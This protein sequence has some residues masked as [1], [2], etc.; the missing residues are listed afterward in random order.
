MKNVLRDRAG[1]SLPEFLAYSSVSRALRPYRRVPHF[2]IGLVL[3]NWERKTSYVQAAVMFIDRKSDY[4]YQEHVKIFDE[5]RS[6]DHIE[7]VMD[8]LQHKQTIIFFRSGD[9]IPKDLR[10]ALDIV[11][12]IEPPDIRQARGV[13]RWGYR[14]TVTDDQA[15]AL[16]NCDWRRLK[17]AMTWGRPMPRVLAIVEK[18]VQAG[19]PSVP[20]APSQAGEILSD[21]RLEDMEGYGDAK[22]W[23]LDL[24][25][26]LE[27]WRGGKIAWDDVDK[28]VLLSGPPGTGKTIF[29]KALAATCKANL[30]VASYAKWQGKGHLG[31]FLKAMQRS[32]QDSKKNAP[33]ILFIDEIDAFGS[34]D[35]VSTQNESYDTKAINGLLEQLDGLEGRE[36]VIVVAATN[37]P[38]KIDAA[39]L[40]SGRLDRQVRIPL[41]DLKARAAIFRMHLRDA[42]DEGRCQSFAELSDGASGADIQKIVRNARRRARGLRRPVTM[43]DVLL[44]LPIPVQIPPE[45]LRVNAVHEIG[46]AIVGV[47]LGMELISVEISARILLTTQ[48]QPVGKATFGRRSWAR[49]TKAHYLDAIAMGLGGM[50]AEQLLLGCHDDGVAGGRGSDLYDATRTAILL[51]RSFGMGD[52]LASLGDISDAPIL[53]ISRMDR[54]VLDRADKMLREQLERATEIL[55]R[56]RP[57]CER[58]VDALVAGLELSGQEVLDALDEEAHSEPRAL[59]N[60]ARRISR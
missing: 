21:I 23:G 14:T 50:A 16:I 30:V 3:E 25:R 9:A 36:G 55:E 45:T 11:I 8:M 10:F 2:A 54:S 57:A 31:E 18:M 27:D 26:D 59:G 48:N 53:D 15:E 38:H 7:A 42:F 60:P 12:K 5:T 32:F 13:V 49:R 19:A 29:A 58:L 4:R 24:A 52:G 43:A 41:P 6:N 20:N 34:R 44:H 56:H 46:H 33:A 1:F 28:G 22:T 39:I 17:L 51:D 35:S 40:R 47:A 37:N